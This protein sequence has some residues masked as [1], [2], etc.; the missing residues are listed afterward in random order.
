MHLA[1]REKKTMLLLYRGPR[2]LWFLLAFM[3][4]TYLGAKIYMNQIHSSS[5]IGNKNAWVMESLNLKGGY[6]NLWLD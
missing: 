3:K 1:V 4:L 5:V 2:I 6:Q